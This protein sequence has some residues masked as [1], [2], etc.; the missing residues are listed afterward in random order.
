[1]ARI[2]FL[3]LLLLVSCSD[4]VNNTTTTTNVST[5]E[6]DTKGDLY[7]YAMDAISG[8][9]IPEVVFSTPA[10]D[11]SLQVVYG[12]KGACFPDLPVGENY[13]IYASAENYAPVVCNAS[14]KFSENVSSPS[15]S[16]VDNSTLNIGM[17][18]L[19]SS[20]RGSIYYQNP[21]NPTQL[22]ILPAAG[23]K[24]TLVVQDSGDCTFLQKKY[25]P[26]KVDSNG[27]FAFDSLPEKANFVL[28]VH[29][30]KF[31][32]FLFSG[33]EQEGTLGYA[34]TATVLPKIVFEKIQTAFGFDFIQD[35][36]SFAQKKDSLKFSFSEPVNNT[37]LQN[38]D[39][40][41]E[42]Q[43]DS[44]TATAVAINYKWLDSNRTLRI[45]PAF[46]EWEFDCRYNIHLKLHS[47]YS[48]ETIDTTLEFTVNEFFDLS[49][50]KV[51]GISAPKINYNTNS[52][53]LKWESVSGADAYEIYTKVPSRSE[54]SFNLVGA[55]T[56]I[57]KGKLD[58]TFTLQ[59]TGMFANGDSICVLVA[60]RN[61]KNRTEFGEPFV[62]KDNTRP[63]FSKSPQ[64]NESDTA[65]FV[66]DATTFFKT[67]AEGTTTIEETFNEPM[68]TRDSLEIELPKNSP[69]NLDVS[70]TWK[71]NTNLS[72]TIKVKAGDEYTGEEALSLPIVI[73][74][75][76]DIA[77]NK[78][79][80]PKVK[81]K[82]WENLVIILHVNGV[83]P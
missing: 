53:A 6:S 44:V 17:N 21:E 41:V 20:L 24:V 83:T 31:K 42:K 46:G 13:A 36:R 19:A 37:A 30:T 73:K 1:M 82:T 63:E 74:G 70:W 68:N 22:D 67:T 8:E 79:N 11:D 50:K 58:T 75:L 60:A 28:N 7:V 9:L 48:A 39:I 57:T 34:K 3:F 61:E 10:V 69:R 25:G 80:D 16:F 45:A 72:L 62:L 5:T 56:S 43:I 40:R 77:G 29:D 49:E 66:I 65:N 35:N 55:I 12:E 76:K 59:T 47:A 15:M 32:G 27:Y 38:N 2:L 52:V 14:I 71:S 33:M 26:I 4:T 81:D 51:S 18:K 54:K 78:I 64:A 23:A